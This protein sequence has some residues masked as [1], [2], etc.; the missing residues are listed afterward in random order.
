[1]SEHRPEAYRVP[2]ALRIAGIGRTYL[3]ELIK[4]NRIQA[5]KAGRRTLIVADSL[6]AWLASLPTINS[7]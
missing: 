2:D 1:M 3:Y 4:Q 5:K 6:H 7:K